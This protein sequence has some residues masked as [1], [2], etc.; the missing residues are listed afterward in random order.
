ME[1]VSFEE[2]KDQLL[3]GL[4]LDITNE[5]L[6]V[7]VVGFGKMGLLHSSILNLLKPNTV[8]FVVDSSRLITLGGSML[9]KSVK[10]FRNLERLL[11]EDFDAV[12]VTTP[13]QTHFPIAKRLLDAGVKAFFMEKPPT[14]SLAEFLE[15]CDAAK[16][17][18]IMVGFQKRYALTF[19][20]A[21]LL[22]EGGVVGDIEYVKCYIKSGDVLHPTGRFDLLGRG[23]LLDLGIHLLD[24]LCWFFGSLDVEEARAESIFTHVD[25][26]FRA[27]LK[28]RDFNVEFESTWSDCSFRLPETCMEIKGNKGM[29]KISEDYVKFELKDA[30]EIGNKSLALYKPHYY[31][32]FPPVLVA[33]PEYTIEDM[34]FL[35]C[36]GRGSS[37]E[38]SLKSC[39]ATMELLEKLY[40]SI[41]HG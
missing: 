2:F 7:A 4:G 23:V 18:V 19:R 22:L 14:V 17:S 5:D 6:R 1:L 9:I 11:K 24:I 40:G 25:D 38:T 10:F 21:K 16:E 39:V 8:R 28:A 27:R 37:P 36:I 3:G 29:I 35:N 31:Q 30:P 20:H 33:D 13:A 32:G 41:V 26:S 15:L 34:H 12:Y